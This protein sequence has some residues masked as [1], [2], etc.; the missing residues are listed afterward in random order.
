MDRFWLLTW[1]TYGTW[2][3]GD[4]R[5]SVA[6][7]RDEAGRKV[8]HNLPGTEHLADGPVLRE[9]A[10]GTMS[11]PPVLLS[12]EHAL[13]LRQQFE[14]TAR[15]RGW[16]ILAGAV[17]GNHAHLVVGVPGD[18]EPAVLLR[19]FKGYGSRALNKRWPRPAG[20]TWW[21]EG[22][23]RRK[24]PDEAAVLSAVRYVRE[25][26]WPLVVWGELDE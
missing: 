9:F 17:M 3:P 7:V 5:G 1:T 25:Q 14:E 6:A 8:W 2:L 18:P 10:R 21:T 20:G 19:D 23:S 24:L 13:A 26:A 4:D 15:L 16:S 11:G 22:G 12:R